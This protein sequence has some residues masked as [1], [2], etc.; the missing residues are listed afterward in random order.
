MRWREK[1]KYSNWDSYYCLNG[2]GNVNGWFKCSFDIF[3]VTYFPKTS[4]REPSDQLWLIIALRLVS[5]QVQEIGISGSVGVRLFQSSFFHTA[6]LFPECPAISDQLGWSVWRAIPLAFHLGHSHRHFVQ[7][8]CAW[9]IT[10]KKLNV[11][12]IWT[13][14]HPV[15]ANYF[16]SISLPN[17]NTFSRE[18]IVRLFFNLPKHHALRESNT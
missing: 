17:I 11:S 16:F 9:Q 2:R 14:N 8:F 18:R 3:R 13:P 10:I 4:K 6:L 1:G 5:F 7:S 15:N 12:V